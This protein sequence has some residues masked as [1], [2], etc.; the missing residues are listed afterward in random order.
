[1]PLIMKVGESPALRQTAL[2]SGTDSFREKLSQRRNTDLMMYTTSCSSKISYL[3]QIF[4]GRFGWCL[5][6]P[7][8]SSNL[9]SNQTTACNC[10]HH[11]I[12]PIDSWQQLYS[13]LHMAIYSWQLSSRQVHIRCF[14][15][16]WH[17]EEEGEIPGQ[18]ATEQP[19]MSHYSWRPPH[20]YQDQ[21]CRQGISPRHIALKK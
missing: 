5:P 21:D 7:L 16:T 19:V 15:I 14:T 18:H 13:S 3:L 4:R 2:M 6:L 9:S 17:P 12:W 10:T 20:W 8:L 11:Y 1:M